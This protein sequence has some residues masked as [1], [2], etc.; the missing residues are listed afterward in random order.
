MPSTRVNPAREEARGA[1]ARTGLARPGLD[2]K[3]PR[4]GT[5]VR[6]TS[7]THNSQWWAA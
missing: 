5:V 2:R 7:C 6:M 1:P 3:G 4:G